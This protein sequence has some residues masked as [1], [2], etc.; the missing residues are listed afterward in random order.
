MGTWGKNGKHARI[1]AT[2]RAPVR[3]SGVVARVEACD[4]MHRIQLARVA[5]GAVEDPGWHG[6]DSGRDA[7]GA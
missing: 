2:R 7:G 1:A 3:A 5:A 4:P 6:G